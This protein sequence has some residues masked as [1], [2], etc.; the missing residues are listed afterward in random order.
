MTELNPIKVSDLLKK[1]NC[2]DRSECI[3]RVEVNNKEHNINVENFYLLTQPKNS[4]IVKPNLKVVAV[5]K[6]TQKV[7]NRNIFDIQLSTEA[8]APFVVLDFK[9]DSKISGQFP[10]NGFFV[11]D[12][13]KNITFETE[14]TLTE[15]QIKDNLVIKTLTDVK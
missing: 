15:Q 5:K 3:V 7:D 11:F 6:R 12:T 4:K 14:S 1:A 8:V 2:K 9:Y 13:H 10:N